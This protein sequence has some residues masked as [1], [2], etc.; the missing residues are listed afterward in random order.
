MRQPY[1]GVAV[2][3][4]VT[5]PYARYSI[6]AAHWWLARAFAALLR[7][8]NLKKEEVDGLTVS[9]FTLAEGRARQHEQNGAIEP[10]LREEQHERRQ[11]GRNLERRER[12]RDDGH[13]DH[14]IARVDGARG[15]LPE[16]HA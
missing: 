13:V 5:I 11:P 7:Q 4:P 16:A 15:V 10:R 12:E 3:A 6:R 9:S 2:A 8:S 14:G 1:E